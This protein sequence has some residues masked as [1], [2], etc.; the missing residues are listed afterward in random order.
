VSEEIY[1]K[2]LDEGT[3]VW[4]PV[5]ASRVAENVF[6]IDDQPY[7]RSIERWEFEPGERVLC[8]DVETDEGT[9]LAAKQTS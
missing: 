1:V 6:V 5:Q 7:D 8:D 3:D 2:L 9:I 4:R